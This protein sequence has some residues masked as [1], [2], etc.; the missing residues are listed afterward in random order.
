MKLKGLVAATYT[1]FRE[2][3][4][5]NRDLIGPMTDHMIERGVDGFYVCG[6]TGECESLTTEERKQIAAA[7]VTATRGRIPVAIQVGHN[8]VDTAC[9]LAAHAESIGADAISTLPPSYFKPAGPEALIEFIARVAAAAPGLP[10]YYYHIPRTSGVP[11]DTVRLLQLASERVPN[12]AGIK[13]SDFYLAEMLA[14]QEFGGGRYNILFGSDQMI[15]GAMAMGSKGAVG[16]CY[17]F[18]APLWQEIITA[19][20][21]GERQ[22]ALAWMSKAAWLIRTI[23]EECGPFQACVKEVI[24]PL[25]GFDIGC[26]RLPQPRMKAAQIDRAKRWLEESGAGEEIATGIYTPRS[27]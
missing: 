25:L 26:L 11:M 10:C 2:D 6:G 17:G 1:P 18:A 22:A 8:A 9:E 5:V 7:T 3:G 27:V 13:F 24:W 15:L 16:S 19:F 21:A 14:C 12:F 20:E 4:T 23:D